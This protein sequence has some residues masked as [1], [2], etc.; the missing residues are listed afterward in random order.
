MVSNLLITGRGLWRSHWKNLKIFGS[1]VLEQVTGPRRP[2]LLLLS[3]AYS[4]GEPA[5]PIFPLPEVS[6]NACIRGWHGANKPHSAIG[7]LIETFAKPVG[8]GV[9]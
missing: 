1:P 7:E 4:G 2:L 8:F 3:G 5:S 9:Q 6:E